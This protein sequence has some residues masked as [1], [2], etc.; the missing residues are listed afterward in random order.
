[1][2][3]LYEG[4]SQSEW[5]RELGVSREMIRLRMNNH[6]TPYYIPRRK[7]RPPK[8]LFEGKTSEEWENELGVRSWI[9]C[10]RMKKYG[11][12]YG[13]TADESAQGE[14]HLNIK[15][16]IETYLAESA[17][18]EVKGVKA[19]AARA[20]GAL[21]ELTKLSKTRRQEIQDKKNAMNKGPETA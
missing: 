20:R 18:F 2:S 11:N 7:G 10:H 16:L 3:N 19:A 9:I 13:W 1:M 4:K 15:A 6:G 14:T 8:I 5:G 12:P 17:K 21:M